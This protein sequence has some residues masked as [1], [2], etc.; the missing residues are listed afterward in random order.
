M[1]AMKYVIVRCE[2]TAPAGNAAS[3]LDG[4]KAAYLQQLGQAGAGLDDDVIPVFATHL[5]HF[6]A[7]NA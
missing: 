6:P 2:D 5:L 7:K 3:L 4:A 1:S